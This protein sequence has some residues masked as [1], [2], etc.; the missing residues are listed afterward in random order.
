MELPDRGEV[1]PYCREKR[2]SEPMTPAEV[3]S[4]WTVFAVLVVLV[5]VVNQWSNHHEAR[6]AKAKL[7]REAIMKRFGDEGRAAADQGKIPSLRLLR[8]KANEEIE[9]CKQAKVDFEDTW[10]NLRI[11][12]G[13]DLPHS[14][15]RS[16]YVSSLEKRR[17]RVKLSNGKAGYVL[18][19]DERF[20]KSTIALDDGK[21][22]EAQ[23]WD[24][25]PS[26]KHPSIVSIEPKK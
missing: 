18:I 9:A 15:W 21:S 4:C 5:V 6:K 16:D 26:Q 25:E 8:D 10:H 22:E 14:S 13:N 1:C 19:G 2:P 23:W 11:T 17:A 7:V 20:E 3:R 12:S 24:G